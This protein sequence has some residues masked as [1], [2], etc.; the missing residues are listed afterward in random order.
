MKVI[1]A[2]CQYVMREDDFSGL[3]DSHGICEKCRD[4]YYPKAGTRKS[5]RVRRSITATPARLGSLSAAEYRGPF[6]HWPKVDWR[7]AQ[8]DW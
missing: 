8:G 3:P 1:C 7:M 4:I 2:W 6:C 5:H